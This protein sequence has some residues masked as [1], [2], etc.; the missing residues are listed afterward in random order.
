MSMHC[1][2]LASPTAHQ[3]THEAHLV[4]R[5]AQEMLAIGAEDNAVYSLITVRWNSQE[6]PAR[7]C[8]EDAH[9]A[10]EACRSQSLLTNNESGQ[11]V[12]TPVKRGGAITTGQNSAQS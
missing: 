8:I 1:S 6:I 11:K 3:C 9:L 7:A 10:V 4:V 5:P 2:C 12:P